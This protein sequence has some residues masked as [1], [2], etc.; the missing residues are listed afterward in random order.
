MLWHVLALRSSLGL[1]T[2]PLY[3]CTALCLLFLLMDV[4]LFG[5]LPPV[6]CC[7]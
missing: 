4:P 6:G 3:V 2:I 1:N 5:L 7:E